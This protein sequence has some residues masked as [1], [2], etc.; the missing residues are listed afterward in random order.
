M[1]MTMNSIYSK[2]RKHNIKNYYLLIFCIILS[3]VLVTSYAIMFFSPTVQNVFPEGGDSR[4]QAYFIFSIAIIGCAIFTTYAASLFFRYRSYET[5]V[6]LSLGASKRSIRKALLTDIT[7]IISISFLGGILLSLPISFLIWKLF[8]ILVVNTQE[9]KY[10]VGWDGL[11]FGVLFCIFVTICIAIMT[12]RFI[13]R[14]DIMSIL[15]EHRKSEPVKGIKKWYGVTG[16][17]MVVAGLFLAIVV[18]HIVFTYFNYMLSGIWNITYI[19][20]LVGIYMSISYIIMYNKKGKNPERYYRNIIPTSMMKFE[21]RQTI[22][23][24]CVITILIVG[25]LFAAFYCPV[26]TVPSAYSLTQ[27]P[28]D[29]KFIFRES[30][31]AITQDEVY[32]MADKYNVKITS[33]D[34]IESLLLIVNGQKQTRS[35]NDYTGKVTYTYIPK[36]SYKNFVSA[37][38]FNRLTSQNVS[39]N[40]GEYM[41]ILSNEDGRRSSDAQ[42][43]DLLTNPTN[44]QSQ[45]M[46]Y[47]GT[48]IYDPLKI[49][50]HKYVTHII[51]DT[52]YDNYKQGLSPD[53]IEYSTFFNVE[54]VESS[55]DF[56]N[57]LKNLYINRS[58][59]YKT[60][61][62]YSNEYRIKEEITNNPEMQEDYKD[63]FLEMDTENS[64]LTRYWRYYPEFKILTKNDMV[65]NYSVF[66]MMFVYITIICFAAVGVIA[67]TRSITIAINNQMLFADLKKLGA[68]NKYVT[69]TIRT[70]LKKIFIIPTL[71]GSFVMMFLFTFILYSNSGSITYSEAL[72]LL[73]NSVVMLIS[74][75]Y[76][77]CVYAFAFRKI[78]KMINIGE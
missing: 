31:E 15:R 48:V 35:N 53:N 42:Y 25:A 46:V 21:G 3:V 50:F 16:L 76:M 43:L 14:S 4:K 18:P 41:T 44:N 63:E 54:D 17:I 26:I 58:N 37:S 38:E 73:V 9:M 1:Q 72:T 23:N 36:L 33:Y 20:A 75:G 47:A 68:N 61:G 49:T 64:E 7:I 29:F 40:S 65:T 19:I 13:K 32:E 77:G 10:T 60:I 59:G 67:Y 69:K 5:G 12:H 22:K 27:N 6:L 30:E 52:D 57:A 71:L 66:I 2:L 70:Q 56:A 39:L 78:R 55:Y 11:I 45:K 34:G 51:S 28:I 8:Q 24:M 74:W 62:A